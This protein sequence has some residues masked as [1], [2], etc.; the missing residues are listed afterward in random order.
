MVMPFLSFLEFLKLREG[1]LAA[2]RPPAPGLSG[3]NVF[4]VTLQHLKRYWPKTVKVKGPLQVPPT[5]ASRGPGSWSSGEGGLKTNRPQGADVP[6][7]GVTSTLSSL[8]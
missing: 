7:F 6:P 4:P 1:L 2:D 8:R 3:V 5:D